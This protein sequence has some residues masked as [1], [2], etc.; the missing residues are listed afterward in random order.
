MSL[1]FRHLSQQ[2]CEIDYILYIPGMGMG[3]I[4]LT[5]HSDMT[6][7]CSVT[8][9]AVTLSE[10][11]LGLQGVSLKISENCYDLTAAPG[12]VWTQPQ[13]I[14]FT[15]YKLLICSFPPSVRLHAGHGAVPAGAHPPSYPVSV[16]QKSPGSLDCLLDPESLCTLGG[17]PAPWLLPQAPD[18]RAPQTHSRRQQAGAGGSLQVCHF[19]CSSS[20]TCVY[21][22]MWW[23]S[24]LID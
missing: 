13:L 6:G 14:L 9:S 21:V 1:T 12:L 11:T 18:D 16:W 7:S 2:Y 4:E 8:Q 5:D 24:Q 20:S 19:F 10:P 23:K 22:W 3:A 15:M 17:V